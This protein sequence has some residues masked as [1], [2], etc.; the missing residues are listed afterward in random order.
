MCEQ[1][2]SKS[3][4]WIL[5]KFFGGVEHGPRTNRLHFVISSWSGSWFQ[6]QNFMPLPM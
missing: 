6:I 1:N 5:M 2:I 3:Y 4:E